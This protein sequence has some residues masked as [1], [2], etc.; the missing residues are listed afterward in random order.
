M[1]ERAK[2]RILS[3]ARDPQ[4]QQALRSTLDGHIVN[5]HKVGTAFRNATLP[6]YGGT[7]TMVDLGQH[8]YSKLGAR[9][10]SC[11]GQQQLVGTPARVHERQWDGSGTWICVGTLS[12]A[13]PHWHTFVLGKCPTGMFQGDAALYVRTILYLPFILQRG[14]SNPKRDTPVRLGATLIGTTRVGSSARGLGIEEQRHQVQKSQ[15]SS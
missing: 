5:Q 10:P 8:V 2:G 3:L 4:L 7:H 6:Q 14:L 13:S 12:L 1:D 11:C 9:R 15:S